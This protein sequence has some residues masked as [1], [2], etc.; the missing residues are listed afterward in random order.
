[1]VDNAQLDNEKQGFVYQLD[2]YKD[3]IEEME[4][5]FIRIQK[6]HKDKN[7]VSLIFFLILTNS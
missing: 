1:M 5:N 2:L 4:E 3:E 7:R 6:E